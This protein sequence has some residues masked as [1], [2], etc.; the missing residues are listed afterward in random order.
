MRM[1]P[2]ALATLM[3]A[4]CTVFA[5]AQTEPANPPTS[6]ASPGVGPTTQSPARGGRGGRGAA[7]GPAPQQF[8]TQI[9]DTSTGQWYT[10]QRHAEY[11]FGADLSSLRQ[12][13]A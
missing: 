9:Q 1:K 8:P 13:E 12:T 2:M 4:A 6:Q 7:R 11:A 5:L 3:I 10:P